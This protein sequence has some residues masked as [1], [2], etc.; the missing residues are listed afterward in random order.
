[1]PAR[2]RL[3]RPRVR[4]NASGSSLLQLPGTRLRALK[5]PSECIGKPIKV[6]GA[7]Y[8]GCN[9]STDLPVSA[10]VTA[11]VSAEES[12]AVLS[13]CPVAGRSSHVFCGIAFKHKNKT[14]TVAAEAAAAAIA[15][16]AA[17]AA[18]MVAVDDAATVSGCTIS[19]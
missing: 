10:D 18:M 17:A 11:S 6:P 9:S 1:M 12:S 3:K 4:D 14:T 8:G 19:P 5:K 7:T 13:L 15:A 16:A 2:D